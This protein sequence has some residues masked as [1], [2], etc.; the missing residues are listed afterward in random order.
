MR[1]P[2]CNKFVSMEMSEPELESE[3]EFD[4]EIGTILGTVR[5]ERTC[6]ECG[7]LLKEGQLEM[8]GELVGEDAAMMDAHLKLHEKGV[9]QGVFEVRDVG[10]D[11]I[12]EGGY[13]SDSNGGRRYNKS[14]YGAKVH[15]T[16]ECSCDKNFAVSGS[17]E[18][19]M[20]ASDMDEV[21]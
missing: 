7:T 8:E 15:F 19:K 11:T 1:C 13:R 10:L 2:D 4:P 21:A 9:A 14:Y 16:I 12:E 6:A 18:D 5:I 17:M 20:A 3:L